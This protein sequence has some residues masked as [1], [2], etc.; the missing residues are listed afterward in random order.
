MDTKQFAEFAKLKD[1]EAHLKG[2][3]KKVQEEIGGMEKR[4]LEE[5]D[6]EGLMDKITVRVG[7][8]DEGRPLTRTIYRRRQLW[9]GHINGRDTLVEALKDA[10]LD[11]FVGETFNAQTL[12]AYVRSF[13]PDGRLAPEEVKALLPQAIQD[14]IKVTEKH[15]LRAKR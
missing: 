4:L 9:A 11:E 5:M 15:E 3:L 1:Q 14:Q 6:E 12:S 8:D 7:M 10:G 2:E 13:D